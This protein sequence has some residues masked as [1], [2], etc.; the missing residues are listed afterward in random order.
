MNISNSNDQV[1]N[2]NVCP[3][4]PDHQNPWSRN[5]DQNRDNQSNSS[6]DT[7][8]IGH[9]DNNWHSQKCTACGLHSHTAYNCE[10]KRNGELYCNRC[11]RYTHCDAMCSVL[12]N[13]STPR[14][15]HH[16][17]QGHPSPHQDGNHT[18]PPAEPNFTTRPS[19]APSN[20]GSITDITQMFVTHLDEIR[21]QAKLIE[22]RKD[23]LAN[24][25]T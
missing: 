25:S 17:Y 6:S 13:T 16:H 19:P 8:S 24:V 1:S 23:L 7:N 12:H 15:Q 11:R 2:T 9:W 20:A 22:Y 3:D 14:F 18:V 10:K 4:R 5:S 21:Q